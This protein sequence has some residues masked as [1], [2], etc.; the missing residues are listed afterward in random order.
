MAM[1]SVRVIKNGKT[2]L[3]SCKGV[4]DFNK[5]EKNAIQ[6]LDLD[7]TYLGEVSKNQQGNYNYTQNYK[8]DFSAEF[9]IENINK[10]LEVLKTEFPDFRF[11]HKG[12]ISRTRHSLESN[13]NVKL[14]K[15]TTIF[16]INLCFQ[17]KESK[18]I[19]DG[20][21]SYRTS[22]GVNPLSILDKDRRILEAYSKKITVD[23]G[24]EYILFPDT[25]GSLLSL[26]NENLIGYKYHNGSCLLSKHKIG[27]QFLS[28][29]FT[30]F[31]VSE[32]K[33][34]SVFI[35]FDSEGTIRK[36]KRVLIEN[37]KLNEFL[38]DHRTA[39]ETGTVSTGNGFRTY[40][41]NPSPGTGIFRI[42][43]G[44]KSIFE[45]INSKKRV[46]IPLLS[47]G[48][49]FVSNGD[50]STPVQK[51]LVVCDGEIQGI[52]GPFIARSSLYKM[53][54]EDL[55]EIA[56]DSYMND[57]SQPSLLIKMNTG[58]L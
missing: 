40:R 58:A 44:E 49:S 55:I 23:Y 4:A 10:L 25:H 18:D 12:N 51:A 43:N 9:L 11:F 42:K 26:F 5:L 21:V 48:G 53:F 50:F 1:H 35:P 52:C 57:T 45:I 20:F 19:I 6:A 8:G 27:E 7:I 3:S 54:G 38:F 13:Q 24:D 30:L 31:D 17:H 56:S 14:S 28:N 36:T 22:E 16:S 2:G 34:S 15:D 32:D 46:L 41:S 47:G 37:G 29:N 39:H 33:L